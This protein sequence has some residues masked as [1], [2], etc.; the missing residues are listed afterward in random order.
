MEYSPT[1]EANIRSGSVDINRHLWNPKFHNCIHNRPSLEPIMNHMN[2]VYFILSYFLIINFNII[3]PSTLD[4]LIGLFSSGFLTKILC[5]FYISPIRT[6]CPALLIFLDL[7]P[8]ITFGDEQK[9][10]NSS[11]CTFP[12]PLLSHYFIQVYLFEK[13]HFNMFP[14]RAIT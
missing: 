8:L 1:S 10:W 3:L 9:L 7:I 4:L 6:T 5:A 11:L 12:Q 2:L 14:L 13:M